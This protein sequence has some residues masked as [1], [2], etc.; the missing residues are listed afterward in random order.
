MTFNKASI[1]MSSARKIRTNKIEGELELF[2]TSTLFRVTM[3]IPT[4]KKLKF[5]CS[6][7]FYVFKDVG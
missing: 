3:S 2:G 7:T 5:F 1:W 6:E 4:L